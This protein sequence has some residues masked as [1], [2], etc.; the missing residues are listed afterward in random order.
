MIHKDIE[1]AVHLHPAKTRGQSV[2]GG[3]GRLSQVDNMSR[4]VKFQ[5]FSSELGSVVPNAR[6]RQIILPL[7]WFYLHWHFFQEVDIFICITR[8]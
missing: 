3:G 7:S 2:C 4:M 6:Y 8:L 5:E 1:I